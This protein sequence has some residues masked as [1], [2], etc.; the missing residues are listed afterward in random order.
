MLECWAGADLQQKQVSVV[1][2]V[3]VEF[4]AQPVEAGSSFF[5]P[6]FRTG[7][8]GLRKSGKTKEEGRTS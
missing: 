6:F 1:L 4:S 5:V 2:V 8:M 7:R 3:A